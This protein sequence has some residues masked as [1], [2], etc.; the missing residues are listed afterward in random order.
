ME[1]TEYKPQPMTPER[2]RAA[3]ETLRKYREG[4]R[5]LE[6]RIIDNE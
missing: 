5:N 2:L 6:Q 1:K 4:K 3:R